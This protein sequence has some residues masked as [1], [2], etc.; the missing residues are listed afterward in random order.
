MSVTDFRIGAGALS[1]NGSDVGYTTEE[2]VVVSY[3][4]DIHEHLS[5]KFG[6]TPV[7][8]SLVGMNLTLEVSMA[9]HTVTNIAR[10]FAGVVN[11][12]GKLKFGGLAGRQIVG[13]ELILTP[14]DGTPAWVFRNAV[15]V[16]SVETNYKVNDERVIQVTFKA[17]VDPDAPDAENLGYVS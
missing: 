2:G 10:A 9:E 13:A 8:A 11:E 7:K 3:E 1:I 15:P 14:F 4:P 17:L 12:D 16:S 5:G 6:T